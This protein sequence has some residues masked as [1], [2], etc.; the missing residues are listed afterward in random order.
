MRVYTV[1][2]P[3][4][5]VSNIVA[6]EEGFNWGAFIFSVLWALFNRLW[7]WSLGI[8]IV[9]VFVGWFLIELGGDLIVQ[10]VT[11]FGLALIIG[12]TANDFKRQ[13]LVKRGF[14]EAAIL[15]AD[16]KETAVLRYVATTPNRLI[17]TPRNRAGGPW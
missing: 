7:L 15:L 16:S 3:N 4:D 1:Y 13:N 10:T 14:K 2:E 9:N 5:M 11:F 6:I 17:K 8:V 12:W